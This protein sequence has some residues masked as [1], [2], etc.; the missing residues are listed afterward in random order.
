MK[1]MAYEGEVVRSEPSVSIIFYLV[2]NPLSHYGDLAD[3]NGL[4]RLLRELEPDDV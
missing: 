3:G 4:M 2:S 1:C